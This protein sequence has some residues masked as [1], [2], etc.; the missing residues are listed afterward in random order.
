MQAVYLSQQRW[1]ELFRSLPDVRVSTF[2]RLPFRR[3]VL[4]LV[5]P[6]RLEVMFALDVGDASRA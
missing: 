1:D 6:N 3:G 4:E 2:D 5:F